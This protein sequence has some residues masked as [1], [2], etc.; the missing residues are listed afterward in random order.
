M[1]GSGVD[2]AAPACTGRRGAQFAIFQQPGTIGNPFHAPDYRLKIHRTNAR[3]ASTSEGSSGCRIPVAFG[4]WA[5]VV[6]PGTV[7]AAAAV[8]I[9]LTVNRTR[10]F[11]AS[12]WRALPRRA[13][14]LTC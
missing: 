4:L 11:V 7:A 8:T 13:G 9:T 2:P 10:R 3:F 14:Y 12:T 5:T 6:G 1:G